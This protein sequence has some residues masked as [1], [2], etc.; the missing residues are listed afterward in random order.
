VNYA[1]IDYYKNTYKGSLIP[2]AE[3][4]SLLIQASD[5]IDQLSYSNIT[6]SGGFDSLTAFQK[7]QVQMATCLQAEHLF[8][9]GDMPST[10]IQSY[11]VGD[12]TVNFGTNQDI[13]YS[14]RALDYLTPTN[15]LYRGLF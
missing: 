4:D 12:N 11:K 6:Q 9:Y 3:L 7:R 15:L 13:R 8:N 1:T 2:D 5:D 10:S 14:R